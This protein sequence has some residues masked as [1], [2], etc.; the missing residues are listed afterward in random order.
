M[1]DSAGEY[2]RR[3]P[4][5]RRPQIDSG[6]RHRDRSA[7]V[8]VDS[9][10]NRALGGACGQFGRFVPIRNAECS[11]RYREFARFESPSGS[12]YS[13]DG[14]AISPQLEFLSSNGP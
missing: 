1:W 9:S 5:C 4:Q 2:F 8:G 6:K 11:G 14:S 12:G 13:V 7:W 3:G 10:F